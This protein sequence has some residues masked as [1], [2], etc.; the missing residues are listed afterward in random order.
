MPLHL[1]TF[2]LSVLEPSGMYRDDGKRPDGVTL[3]SWSKGKCL[4]W[5]ATWA[6]TLAKGYSQVLPE[7]PPLMLRRGSTR[8][9]GFQ[10][11]SQFRSLC[12]GNPRP[13]WWRSSCSSQWFWEN[14]WSKVREKRDRRYLCMIHDTWPKASAWHRYSTWKCCQYVRR[15]LTLTKI[16][17]RK[18]FYENSLLKISPRKFPSENFPSKIPLAKIPL[19]AISPRF[20]LNSPQIHT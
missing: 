7:L 14:V 11:H 12:G 3:S 1:F 8:R 19:H 13:I 2:L 20:P 17:L 6:N 18:F 5:D 16:T 10:Q 9:R 4:L 15:R